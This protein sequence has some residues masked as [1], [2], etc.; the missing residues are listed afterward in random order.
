M[1]RLI[2]FSIL[3]SIVYTGCENFL[4]EQPQG[5]YPSSAF[6][7][8]EEHAKLAIIAC[9]EP[10]SFANSDNR[11]WV[12]GDVA[13]DDAVKG[14][15]PGDQADIELIDNFQIFP[16]NGNIETT[17]SIY[18]EGVSRCN[19]VIKFVPDIDMDKALRNKIVGE[20]YFL[21]GYYY[22]YLTTIFGDI[23][24]IDRPLNPDEMDVVNTPQTEM[25]DNIADDFKNA[26]DY[27]ELAIQQ[28]AS[29]YSSSEKGRAT[30]GAATAYLAKTYLFNKKYSDAATTAAKV[31]DY[32]FDLM[33]VYQH[34]FNVNY[35]NNIE[36]VFEIQ[37]LAGQSPVTGNRL[38]QWLAPRE[39]NGFGFNEP[40]QDFVDEFEVTSGG[41][42]DPRLDYT[43]GRFEGYWFDIVTYD[44]NWSST[45]YNQK[46]YLQPISEIPKSSKGDGDLNFTTIRFAEVLLIEAEALC[47]LNRCSEALIPLN[48]VRKRARE[49]YLYDEN[50]AGFG[51][52]PTD[53]LPDIVV[54][55]QVAVRLAIRHERRVELGFESIRYFD[56]IRYGEQYANQV[57]TDKENFNYN[58]HKFFPIPQSEID[59]NTE[60]EQNDGYN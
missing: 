28:D 55:E 35:E 2:I 17:W 49:S 33:P 38:N 8:T 7:K 1:K 27:L 50:I 37:H 10:A 60:I 56:I 51:I 53:L 59:T 46:K 14:G 25:Y 29:V 9:Y 32:G 12:F 47:E 20:A 52:I 31:K 22:F 39:D 21:R 23:P 40:T 13:S 41:I 48:K 19:Q 6:Y 11:L 54:T 57:F 36:S 42:V 15:F 43:V 18:Y 30:P 58:T 26:I 44:T 16:D 3:V 24:F 34:N 5:T 4:D 45:N